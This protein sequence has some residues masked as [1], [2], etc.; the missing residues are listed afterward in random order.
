MQI[1]EF[2]IDIRQGKMVKKDGESKKASGNAERELDSEA[3]AGY[4]DER[5]SCDS[6]K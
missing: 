6:W 5:G 1:C 3:A 4:Q 2:D